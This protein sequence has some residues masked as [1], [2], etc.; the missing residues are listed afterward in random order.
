MAWLGY[1]VTYRSGEKSNDIRWIRYNDWKTIDGL[2]L[3]NSI[4]WHTVEDG[5]IK[6]ARNQ[7][8]FENVSI[9]DEAIP[10]SFFSKPEGG[11]YWEKPP[12]K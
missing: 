2:V 11:T 1:T 10:A 7:V 9:S 5:Q 6:E 3:P 12:N 4:S 8:F